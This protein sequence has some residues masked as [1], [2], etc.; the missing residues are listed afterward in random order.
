MLR[1]N[2]KRLIIIERVKELYCNPFQ[3]TVVF[4]R[5]I[6]IQ[7]TQKEPLAKKDDKNI[8]SLMFF[9][10]IVRVHVSRPLSSNF[11][12]CCYVQLQA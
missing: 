10:G 6:K 3:S 7:I 5:T 9:G 2:H 1:K 11:T 4:K 12:K 8:G